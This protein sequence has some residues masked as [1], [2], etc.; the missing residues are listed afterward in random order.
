MKKIVTA[1]VI[2]GS[3]LLSGCAHQIQINPK[4]DGLQVSENMVNKAVGYHIA[5]ADRLKKV[6][7]PG[8]GGD[9]VSYTPYKDVE[10]AL[11][12]VLSNKFSDVYLVKSLEN[13]AFIKDN[14]IELVFLPSIETNSSSSSL[15]TWP[16]TKFTINLSC[17]AINADGNTVWEKVIS[18]EGEAEFSE[19]KNDYSL[20]AKR[21]TEKLFIQLANELEATNIFSNNK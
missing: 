4:T 10:T 17:K 16:P 19:F 5:E 21:A 18:S 9:K 11:Y 8:G 3:L 7:S 20:A 2:V 14:A 15:V 12:T 1:L 6:T 13:K